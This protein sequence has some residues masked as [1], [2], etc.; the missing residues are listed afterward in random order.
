MAARE[1]LARQP[2][3]GVCPKKKRRD[4]LIRLADT[5][6]DWALGCAD[7]AWW[8]RFATPACRAWAEPGRPLRLVERAAAA[9]DREPKALAAYGLYRPAAN[10]V[11][12]RFADGRP[13]GA[14]TTPFLAWCA[15]RLAARDLRALLLIWDNAA[16]HVS[17]E[18]LAWLRAHNRG[19]KRT[20]VGVRIIAWRLPVKRPWLNPIAPQWVHGKR[21]ACSP[22]RTLTARETAERACAALG[23]AY[24]P[25]LALP[26]HAP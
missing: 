24:E 19:V 9:G 2:R 1:A 5:R 17:K 12:L 25:H 8:G 22:D 23:C 18:V 21:R 26:S 4:A 14:L 7:E 10:A 11:L 6:P 16:W 13:V 20:G 3:P 15:D